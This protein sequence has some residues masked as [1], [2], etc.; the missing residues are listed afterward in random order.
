MSDNKESHQWVIKAPYTTNSH[1]IRYAKNFDQIMSCF[2]SACK[3]FYGMHEYVMIQ[4]KM[5]S[6][7]EKRVVLFNGKAQ[8]LMKLKNSKYAGK[9]FLS[10]NTDLFIF[11]EA[12]FA[13]L[14]E[15][16]QGKLIGD[17]LFRVDLF[18]NIRN[19]LV[20]NEFES[21]EANYDSNI[22]EEEFNLFTQ[23]K[24]YWKKK[25]EIQLQK[26]I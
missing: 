17:G 11:A 12:A 18:E 16:T 13:R 1:F 14:K 22:I 2:R 8:Y 6:N 9:K 3:K 4:A 26:F 20:V 21:L 15:K 10:T 5:H 7:T 25:I 23:L 24:F 19:E